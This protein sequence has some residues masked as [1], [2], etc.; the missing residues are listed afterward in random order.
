M[1]SR[2]E[3]FSKKEG[4]LVSAANAN[5]PTGEVE[6][7]VLEAFVF[8]KAETPPF[9]L[10]DSIDTRE[11]VRLEH[12]YLDLRRQPLQSALR[13]RHN[14]NQATRNYLS[15]QGFIEIETPFMVKYTPGGARNFLVPSRLHAGK[16]YALAESPQLFKQLFMVAGFDRYF[17]IVRCFRDED[18]RLDRQPEFTQIDI[19]MSFINQDDLFNLI[20]GLIFTIW[21]DALGIDLHEYFPSGHFPR[22]KFD[23]SMEKYGNDKPDLRFDLRHIDLTELVIEHDGGG[24]PFWSRS[25]RSSRAASTAAICR[26]RS[27]R[28]WSCRP[29]RHCRAPITTSSSSSSRAWARAAWRAPRS[30]R[31][32]PGRS[33][34]LSKTVTREMRA[35]DQRRDRRQRGRSVAVSVRQDVARAHR[36]GQPARAHR[37]EARADPRGRARR[38]VELPLGRRPAAVRV[39]RRTQDAGPPR[40][41]PSRARTTTTST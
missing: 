28:R 15:G 31:T 14:I 37:Q 38:R 13:M 20:E 18:L 23:E 2:G 1:R 11:E 32:A 29:V 9:G 7:A 10:E 40:T 26:P 22:M 21:K 17:Q 36:D 35:G 12:R 3:Q 19:E 33:R 41:T 24:I 25:P 30:A 27:S 8:N 4:K 5:I 16:F 34:R 39:R 6:I